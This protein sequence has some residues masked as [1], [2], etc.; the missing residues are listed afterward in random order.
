MVC[1]APFFDIACN[2]CPQVLT[3]VPLCRPNYRIIGIP[4]IHIKKYMYIQF[5][6]WPFQNSVRIQMHVHAWKKKGLCNLQCR[7]KKKPQKTERH[8]FALDAQ[9]VTR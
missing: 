4:Y 6:T 8:K 9:L 3:L 1:M 7:A 5:P 2:V